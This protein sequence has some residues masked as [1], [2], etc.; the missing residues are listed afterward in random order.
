[1]ASAL[2]AFSGSSRIS[3]VIC[4]S[5]I[6]SLRDGH[7]DHS[8]NGVRSQSK[9]LAPAVLHDAH[10]V[11]QSRRRTCTESVARRSQKRCAPSAQS[12]IRIAPGSRR[13]GF[14]TVAFSCAES[15]SLTSAVNC[16]AASQLIALTVFDVCT[17]CVHERSQN[18]CASCAQPAIRLV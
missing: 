6:N 12:A 5:A 9:S 10:F 2:V 17:K 4:V 14:V 16:A 13:Y 8:G 3:D 18:G 1:S 11:S 7:A 15:N